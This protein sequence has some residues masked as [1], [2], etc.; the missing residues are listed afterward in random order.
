V[1]ITQV[2]AERRDTAIEEVR[3]ILSNRF[4]QFGI[5]E[6]S[7]TQRG[8]NSI[9]VQIPSTENAE[10]ERIKEAIEQSGRLVIHLVSD[11][12]YQTQ[13]EEIRAAQNQHEREWR[14]NEDA[15]AAGQPGKEMHEFPDRIV[16]T[17]GTTGGDLVVESAPGTYVDGEY[18]SDS[19]PT[20]DKYGQPA[21]SFTFNPIGADA[22][23]ELTSDNVGKSLAMVLDGTA[24]SVA[25]I[26]SRISA[27]GQ[28][29]GSFTQQEVRDIVT[30]LRSGSLPVA[31]QYESENRVG[32]LLGQEAVRAGTQAM[33]IGFALVLA[34]L[35]IYY[36][37]LLGG[38]AAT[39]LLFNMTLVFG[40]I[41][42]FRNALTLPGLAGLL[43]TVGMAVDANIL[44]YE[45]IREERQRGRGLTQSISSGFSRAFS[46]I[47]DA[48]L[49][50]LITAW[51]LF[52]NGT[53]AVKG[54]A[55]VLSIGIVCTFFSSLFFS[56]LLISFA[57]KQGFL[58]D[59]KMM[60]LVDNPKIDFLALRKTAK[61]ASIVLVTIGIVCLFARN[62]E[63]LGID[64]TGGT[65]LIAN[66]DQPHT[67][68]EIRDIVQG[69]G[70]DYRDVQ[71]QAINA[72]DGKS[73]KFSIRTR[74]IVREKSDDPDAE[75]SAAEAFKQQ[76]EDTLNERGVLAPNL[77]ASESTDKTTNVLTADINLRGENLTPDKLKEVLTEKAYPVD[78]VQAQPSS[79][80][81]WSTYRVVSTA[82]PNSGGLR[83]QLTTILGE[84]EK[85]GMLERADPFPE[86]N[87]IGSRVAQ[88]MQSKVFLAMLLAFAAIIFYVSLRFHFTYGLAA[89]V[90]LVHDIAFTLGALAVGDLLFGS[91]LNLKINLPVVAALLTVVGYSLNDTIVIFDRIREN[92]GGK[93]RN[94]DHEK[95]VNTSINQT[96]SR[97]LLTSV[98]TFVVVTILLIWGG[99]ALHGFAFALCVGVLVGTYSS[100]Y[101]A[102]PA[103]INFQE[104][105]DKRREAV[106]AEAA[107]AGEL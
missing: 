10:V 61:L 12:A 51:I 32:S 55:V 57:V 78:S 66:L 9:V 27:D 56:R 64:F 4:D 26:Q 50:T 59:V 30:L 88:D 82:Q 8:Y 85:S 83:E 24:K 53:G 58:T 43:L 46:T 77:F 80:G 60:Q 22:F 81:V 75:N 86:V 40:L 90:A 91:F 54:F 39:T 92:V 63:T 104:R 107:A 13:V 23:A 96:L 1:D 105:A 62:T 49:T 28:L 14:E 68:A 42:V 15:K 36:R 5:K 72:E 16:I 97:T 18:L 7:I 41:V 84:Y 95:V 89:I 94:V 45:R 17:D 34:F 19:Q 2:P 102:S 76:V 37:V 79:A 20:I 21:V 70:E 52:V 35:V 44:I 6:L 100:I 25:T 74:T 29:T 11:D 69:I 73:A 48:N 47:L 87:T 103:L 71:V 31:P 65:R 93:K 98:T 38:I 3:Q 99:E 33:A 101:V 67:E 106:L